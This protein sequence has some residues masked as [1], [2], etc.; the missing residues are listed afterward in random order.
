M[1][2]IKPDDLAAAITE[3][4]ADYRD[5]VNKDVENVTKAMG[6]ATRERVKQE[7]KDKNLVRTG[8]YLKSW[9]V[10]V[11]TKGDKTEATIYAT[12]PRYRLTHLLEYGHATANGGRVN[13]QPHIGPAEQ[14]A[15][16]EYERALKEA[17][18]DH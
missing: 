13:G 18:N 11:K 7:S 6:A 12:A 3:I 8:R 4:L 10:K 9:R 14:W 17:I 5:V 16:S 15:V 1:Q 2:A